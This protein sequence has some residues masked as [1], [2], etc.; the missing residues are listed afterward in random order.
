MTRIERM[1]EAKEKIF[2]LALEAKKEKYYSTKEINIRFDL[3]KLFEILTGNIASLTMQKGNIKINDYNITQSIIIGAESGVLVDKTFEIIA[4]LHQAIKREDKEK[5][6]FKKGRSE[7]F[8]KIVAKSP[9]LVSKYGK[10]IEIIIET[11]DG[12]SF[13]F[14]PDKHF[15]EIDQIMNK[16]IK[17]KATFEPLKQESFSK[18]KV[19]KIL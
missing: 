14:L 11:E 8:A 12:F 9:I 3:F 1:V 5:R 6:S 15:K 2:G 10:K 16:T 4:D 19:L 7:C 17:I 18:F 13:G